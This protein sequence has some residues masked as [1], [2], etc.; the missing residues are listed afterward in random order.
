[1]KCKGSNLSNT[2]KS[3]SYDFLTVRPWLK[4]KVQP[5]FFSSQLL[6]VWKSD[7]KLFR[8]LVIAS[9]AINYIW[10]YLKPN[11]TVFMLINDHISMPRL[12]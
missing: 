4:T 5:R 2:W 9:K 7:K 3:V 8:V 12:G 11:C 10:R 1:M 6:G